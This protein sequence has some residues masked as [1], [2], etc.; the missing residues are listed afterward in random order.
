MMILYLVAQSFFNQRGLDE[1]PFGQ[2]DGYQNP[3]FSSIGAAWQNLLSADFLQE[4]GRQF[5][6][7]SWNYVPAVEDHPPEQEEKV[8][9]PGADREIK[10]INGV[11]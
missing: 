1:L 6:C 2:Y 10:Y 9:T 4:S 5:H 7:E 11:K 3:P 8:G